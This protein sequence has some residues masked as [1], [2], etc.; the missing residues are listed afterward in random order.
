MCTQKF[1]YCDYQALMY[2]LNKALCT[3]Y[4][5]LCSS[6]KADT[7]ILFH[8]E[9]FHFSKALFQKYSFDKDFEMKG[10]GGD[11]EFTEWPDIL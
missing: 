3:W 4:E 10:S 1:V 8:A 7:K 11:H 6:F 2:M 9:H 5:S